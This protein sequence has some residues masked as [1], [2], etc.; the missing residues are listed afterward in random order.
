VD[1]AAETSIAYATLD[2]AGVVEHLVE[3]TVFTYANEDGPLIV[4]ETQAHLENNLRDHGQPFLD[5]T[6]QLAAGDITVGQ[7]PAV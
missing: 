2:A 5:V 7:L 6:D 1:L 4:A 3:V